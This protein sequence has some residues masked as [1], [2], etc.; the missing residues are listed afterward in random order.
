MSVNFNSDFNTNQVSKTSTIN[1]QD[2]YYNTHLFNNQGS[3]SD[4]FEY[5]D[6]KDNTGWIIAGTIGAA[7]LA[8]LGITACFKGA[9]EFIVKTYNDAASFFKK[10]ESKT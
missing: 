6:K 3:Q 8:G 4:S 9:R 1:S 5:S 10:A 7:L 2:Q